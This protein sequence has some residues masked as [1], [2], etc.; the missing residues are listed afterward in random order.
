[1]VCTLVLNFQQLKESTLEKI[2]P[3]SPDSAFRVGHVVPRVTELYSCPHSS[4]PPTTWDGRICLLLSLKVYA[5]SLALKKEL[6]A[7][8][9][10]AAVRP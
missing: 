7:R 6:P 9:S 5:F 8:D 1:M 2:V 10:P 3:E 4:A